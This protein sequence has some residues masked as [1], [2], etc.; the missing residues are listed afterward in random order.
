MSNSNI[1]R[2]FTN[3]MPFFTQVFTIEKLYHLGVV[4]LLPSFLNKYL[5]KTQ[6]YLCFC[7]GI[8]GE[9]VYVFTSLF[10]YDL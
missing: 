5:L 8:N 2:R 3:I 7:I 10:K 6:C 1:L 4:N 9:I